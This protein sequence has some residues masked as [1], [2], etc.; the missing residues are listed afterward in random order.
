VKLVILITAEVEK[1]LDIAQAWQ[2]A[3]APGV[4]ILRTHGL[5]TIQRQAEHGE[6]EL[7]RMIGSM[8]SALA[9]IIDQVEERGELI[10]SLVEPAL[11]DVLIAAASGILGDL[12]QPNHGILFVIDVERAIGVR[13][14]GNNSH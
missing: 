10:M 2:E 14:H 3:G 12:N 7:P 13:R 6:V 5:Y 4:T 1:G 9:S 11:V 8:T